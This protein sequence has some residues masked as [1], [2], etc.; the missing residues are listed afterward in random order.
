ME[1]QEWR[2]H[3]RQCGKGKYGEP[4]GSGYDAGFATAPGNIPSLSQPIEHLADGQ[5]PAPPLPDGPCRGHRKSL[6]ST[7]AIEHARRRKWI[8]RHMGIVSED[9]VMWPS[10]ADEDVDPSGPS[11]SSSLSGHSRRS[12]E[13]SVREC[14]SAPAAEPTHWIWQASSS[15]SLES[16]SSDEETLESAPL[17]L[18]PPL[19]GTP[20]LFG[21]SW[22]KGAE[23]HE[24]GNCRPCAWI[25]MEVGCAKGSECPYCHMCEQGTIEQRRLQKRALRQKKEATPGK[26]SL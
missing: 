14:V 11:R 12:S 19:L 24:A 26:F 4:C 2:G 7:A 20:P 23:E 5:E 6:G 21:L 15:G 22:S 25:W 1:D 18:R 10:R 13:P 9:D 16:G 3:S 17:P 8:L